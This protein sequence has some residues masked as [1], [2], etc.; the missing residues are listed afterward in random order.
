MNN[1]TA[2][3]LAG[4]GSRG[5]YELGVWKALKKLGIKIDIITGTSVGALNGVLF[6]AGD[7]KR[8]EKMWAEISTDLVLNCNLEIDMTTPESQKASIYNLV[9]EA[10]R[11][12][13]IDQTPLKTLL[14]DVVDK[15]TFFKSDVDFGT[16]IVKHPSLKHVYVQKKDMNE[17]NLIEYLMATSACYPAMKPYKFDNETYIDGGYYDNLPINLAIEMGA[18]NIISVDLGA[19]GLTQA[20][21][22]KSEINHTKIYPSQDLG[23]F[24][25]FDKDV[26]KDLIEKGYYDTLKI[27]R[28]YDGFKYTFTKNT[29]SNMYNDFQNLIKE[30]STITE[31][32]GV[33]SFVPFINTIQSKIEKA[34]K[35]QYQNNSKTQLGFIA[36]CEAAGEVFDIPKNQTYSYLKF[37]SVIKLAFISAQR[38]AEL[39]KIDPSELLNGFDDS[40][41]VCVHIWRLIDEILKEKKSSVLFNALSQIFPTQTLAAIFIFMITLF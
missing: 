17:D 11:Q 38:E 36:C 32:Q 31:K 29:F 35:Q 12:K 1:K 4:G 13:A 9:T 24:M 30:L 33:L 19:I 3:V 37:I 10:I 20:I 7:E 39:K 8:A 28:E 23:F 18:K 40:K 22:E 21:N 6:S 25:I 5:A 15:Q 2:L 26:S 14:N 27:Y 41:I 16:V 34:V